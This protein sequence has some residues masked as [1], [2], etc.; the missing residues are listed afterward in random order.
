M[1]SK[2]KINNSSIKLYETPDDY[3][4]DMQMLYEIINYSYL[5]Y[6]E[7]NECCECLHVPLDS[8][9]NFVITLD[10]VEL[11]WT[12]ENIV[13]KDKLYKILINKKIGWIHENLLEI[14]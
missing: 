11:N 8:E 7:N 1:L 9:N 14:F 6:G 13:H 5:K 12:F 3:L 4:K 2:L 10:F